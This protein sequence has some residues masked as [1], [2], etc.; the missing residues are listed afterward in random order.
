MSQIVPNKPVTF[1]EKK[2]SAI[3]DQLVQA[4]PK[5]SQKINE[6]SNLTKPNDLNSLLGEICRGIKK[7]QTPIISEMNQI[8]NDQHNKI[9]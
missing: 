9:V 4:K 5:I 6:N 1:G 8:E 3:F 2:T 7:G